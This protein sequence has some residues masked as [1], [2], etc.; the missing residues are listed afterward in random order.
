MG[1]GKYQKQNQL[2]NHCHSLRVKKEKKHMRRECCCPLL[3]WNIGMAVGM[4]RRTSVTDPLVEAMLV[5]QPP[6]ADAVKRE[7]LCAEL[8][9]RSTSRGC[10]WR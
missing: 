7:Q 5:D 10:S 3:C 1:G 6:R 4:D 9:V 8:W 2:G